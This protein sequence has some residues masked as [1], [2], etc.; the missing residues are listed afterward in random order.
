MQIH[1]KRSANTPKTWQWLPMGRGV[2]QGAG[3]RGFHGYS[4]QLLPGR[5]C[6]LQALAQHRGKSIF[7]PI[8]P[9]IKGGSMPPVGTLEG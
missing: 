8:D 7:I 9:D 5:N 2:G 3:K 6:F 1:R 4:L